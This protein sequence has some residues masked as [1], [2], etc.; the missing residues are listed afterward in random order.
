M[1]IVNTD[2]EHILIVILLIVIILPVGDYYVKKFRA[3]FDYYFAIFYA[4]F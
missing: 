4:K 3:K 1:P 2:N